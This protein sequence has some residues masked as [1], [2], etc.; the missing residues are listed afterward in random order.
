MKKLFKWVKSEIWLLL[1]AITFS[2]VLPITYSYVPQFTKYVFD[3]VLEENPDATTTL[4]QFLINF[5]E[6]EKAKGLIECVILVG[7][8]LVVYQI[9]RAFLMFLSDIVKGAFGENISLRMRKALFHKIQ[10]LSYTYHNNCD[11]GD[12]IQRCTSDID[13]ARLF[14]STELTE[15]FYIFAAFIASAVQMSAINYKIMLVTMII[16]PVSLI[17]SIIHFKKM[18][19]EFEKI[20]ELESDM[21]SAIEENVKGIRVVK[22]FSQERN[23]ISKFTEKSKKFR[24]ANYKLSK[25][26]GLFWGISDGLSLLQYALTIG[27]CIYLAEAGLVTTGDIVVCLSY[28]GLLIYPIRSLGRIIN[29]FSKSK[30]AARRIDDILKLD[31]EYLING[32]KKPDING[33]IVFKNVSFKFD[34]AP[35][36]LLHD[37]SFDIK[38]GETVAIVGK[39]GCGKSTIINLLE[40][41]IEY[42]DGSITID[43]VELKDIDKKW[44]RSHIGLVMQDPFLY[45]RSIEENVKITKDNASIEDIYKATKIAKIHEDVMAF[46]KQYATEVG[47]KG[48][49]LSGGQKQRVAIARMLID[50]KPILIFDDSLSAVDTNTDKEIRKALKEDNTDAT[51]II[52]T[53]RI[54]TAKS[55]DKII[56]LDDGMI[57]DI[58]TH[59]TLA[60]KDGIYHELWMIQGALEYK[61]KNVEGGDNND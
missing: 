5:F 21:T 2:I 33:N 12:L 35:S 57:S 58:G 28:I 8:T 11:S 34:D 50:E 10:N 56:V 1:I 45:S 32:D 49:T 13:T 61:F 4:P 9:L 29:D 51:T 6:S 60:N 7:F 42:T 15:I 20:E 3:F 54:T 44:I 55:A 22:A 24:D 37:I 47:E 40:R 48:V 30:V 38:K 26:I 14:L 25:T 17:L 31:S 16:I 19:K 27:Y 18:S 59:E 39:T 46:E 41:L 53:H 52:I 36:P 43:G 23:E